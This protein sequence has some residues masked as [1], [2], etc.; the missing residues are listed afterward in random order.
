MTKS[1]I[2][3]DIIKMVQ[4]AIISNPNIVEYKFGNIDYFRVG[5]ILITRAVDSLNKPSTTLYLDEDCDNIYSVA[6]NQDIGKV[7]YRELKKTNPFI[8]ELRAEHFKA[9]LK[10]ISSDEI[11]DFLEKGFVHTKICDAAYTIIKVVKKNVSYYTIE[12][13][14]DYDIEQKSEVVDENIDDVVTEKEEDV[15]SYVLF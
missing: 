6:W 5:K 2:T 14:S 7:L 15:S 9:L 4:H 11:D 10:R 8:Y 1:L 12:R 13:Y 3:T